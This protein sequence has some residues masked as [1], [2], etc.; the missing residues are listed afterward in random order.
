MSFEITNDSRSERFRDLVARAFVEI[1]GEDLQYGRWTVMMRS[2]R[3]ALCVVMTGP[4]DTREEWTFDLDL[5]SAQPPTEM[6]A[7]LRERFTTST[8]SM[9]RR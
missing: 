8:A 6:T 3:K 4:D 7:Q 2:E 5:S 9:I 1:L